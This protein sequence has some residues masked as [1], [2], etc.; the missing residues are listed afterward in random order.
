[1]SNSLQPHGLYSLWNSSG[2]NTGVGSLSFSSRSSQPRDLTQFSC[3]A[4]RFSAGK[5]SACNAGDPGSVPGWGRC[6]GERLSF[7]YSWAFTWNAGDLGWILRLGKLPGEGKNYPL[8]Y[9]CLRICLGNVIAHLIWD[10]PGSS[11]VK[12][13]PAMWENWVRSLAQ[14]Y[15]LEKS[16]ATHSSILAWKIPSEEWWAT[17]Y[18]FAKRW[19][20]L[21]N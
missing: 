6:R 1:M 2:Q 7:Q 8:Q 18:G 3:I 10:F 4:G 13:L 14:E 11:T 12:N 5:K 21:S 17:V 19:T 15:P 20:Q 9:E 16:M